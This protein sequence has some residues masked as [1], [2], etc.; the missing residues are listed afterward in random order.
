MKIKSL[1]FSLALVIGVQPSM[2][3]CDNE[4]TPK[5]AL[6]TNAG[7]VVGTVAVLAAGSLKLYKNSLVNEL[8]RLDQ[9]PPLTAAQ[10]L[11][12]QV[13]IKRI[14]Y[15]TTA[16]WYGVSAA[17]LSYGYAFAWSRL[18]PREQLSDA[19]KARVKF[20]NTHLDGLVK[21]WDLILAKTLGSKERLIQLVGGLAKVEALS[22][23]DLMTKDGYLDD[24][25]IYTEL[26]TRLR[27]VQQTL[28]QEVA[29]L[30]QG[31]MQRK[32]TE[33]LLPCVD[34]LIQFFETRERAAA[35]LPA[36]Q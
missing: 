36:A 17:V 15:V 21:E 5:T 25:R 6:H 19:L 14:D 3:R 35:V 31:S 9:Q 20:Q 8:N 34:R 7:A 27:Q 23:S 18:G 33:E 4:M 30:V 1:L 2:L 12:R 29:T 10:K 13:L 22:K 24:L 11:Q 28:P 26:V 32:K 16:M